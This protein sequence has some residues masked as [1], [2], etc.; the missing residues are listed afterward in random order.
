MSAQE[1][2]VLLADDHVVM[3]R[4]VRTI[5]EAMP[6]WV[7]CGEVAN[8]REAVETAGRLLPDIAVMD[9]SM[10]ELNGLEATR[11]IKKAW[12]QI[13][14]MMFTGI[15]T[16]D[17]VHQVFEAGARSYILKTDGVEEIEAALCALAA[18][19]PYFTTEI[20]EVLF[21]RFL[22]E[23]TQ[24]CEPMEGSRLTNREREIIQFLGE[25]KSNK[26]VADKL[27]ISVKTAETHRAAIMKKLKLPT[28]SDLVRYAI[29][30]H[31][32]SA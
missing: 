21:A 8:G 11:Q 12:P 20:G 24:T 28:F 31:I 14:V 17:L 19:K 10:P 27:G 2:R 25:G 7:V 16:E 18:H 13:E 1:I 22:R 6:G 15:E 32:I 26:E 9:V 4:G 5:I 29:R 3:R 23:K 30:N